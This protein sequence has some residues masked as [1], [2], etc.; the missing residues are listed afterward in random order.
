M[1]EEVSP[2]MISRRVREELAGQRRK[3]KELAAALGMSEQQAGRRV[4]GEAEFSGAE[5]VATARF[6]G[7]SVD[8]LLGE[9]S[10]D[11]AVAS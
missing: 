5:L 1:A 6:L 9:P 3:Y 7:I 11:R 4:R 2:S 10:G 8:S